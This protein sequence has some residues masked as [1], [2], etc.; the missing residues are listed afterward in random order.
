MTLAINQSPSGIPI[1]PTA[2]ANPLGSTISTNVVNIFGAELATRGEIYQPGLQKLFQ[3]I[4]VNELPES[5][6]YGLLQNRLPEFA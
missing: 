1:S 2:I 5:Q 6:F 3:E 4:K